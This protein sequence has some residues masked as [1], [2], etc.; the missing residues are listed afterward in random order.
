MNKRKNETIVAGETDRAPLALFPLGEVVITAGA[1]AALA[2]RWPIAAAADDP[3]VLAEAVAGEI[4]AALTRHQT[5]DWYE[6]DKA[7]NAGA[8]EHHVRILTQHV[9][10]APAG[11]RH[12]RDERYWIMTD[13]DRSVTTVLLPEEY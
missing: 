9:A 6:D 4:A 8:I 5:G 12:L 11:Y 7:A 1:L 10:Y 2:E 13:A 3:S